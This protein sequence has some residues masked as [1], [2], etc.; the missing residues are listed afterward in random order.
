MD[1]VSQK[2]AEVGKTLDQNWRVTLK[3]VVLAVAVASKNLLNGN[4][5][6]TEACKKAYRLASLSSHS[7]NYLEPGSNSTQNSNN[8]Q[9][10]VNQQFQNVET[11]NYNDIDEAQAQS[12][13]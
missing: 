4:I 7:D 11:T 5:N 6:S 9:R 12:N 13:M 10:F 3:T 8:F 1:D 2:V